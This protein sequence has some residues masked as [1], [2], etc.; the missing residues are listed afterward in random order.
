M[1]KGSTPHF[2]DMVNAR[3][4]GGSGKMPA[5]PMPRKMAPPAKQPKTAKTPPAAPAW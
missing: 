1:A 3:G 2:N 5:A 4:G